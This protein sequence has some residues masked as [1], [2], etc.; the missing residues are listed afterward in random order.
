MT[1]HSMQGVLCPAEYRVQLA[2]TQNHSYLKP[3]A[4]SA[5]NIGEP[6]RMP[7]CYQ[8]AEIVLLQILAHMSMIHHPFRLAT[9][10]TV[11][12]ALSWNGLAAGREQNLEKSF[13][14]T[15][16][17]RL[18]LQAD[19]GSIEITSGGSDKVSVRVERKAKG[20]TE[21]QAEELLAAHEVTFEQAG[22]TVTVAGK[23]K[24]QK[25]WSWRVG[26]PYL[27]VR[28]VVS[29][30]SSFNADLATS[31]GDIRVGDLD[32]ETLAR[33]SSGS[34]KLGRVT[35]K[36]EAS[37]SGG[38]I[39]IA[40]AG[41]GLAART[42]SGS[43]KI[44]EAKSQIDASNSG[45]DIEITEAGGDVSARTSSGSIRLGNA[46]G[47][48]NLR[49]SGGDIKVE[50]AGGTLAAE[51]SSGSIR[52]VRAKGRTVET[53]VSGGDIEIGDAEGAVTAQTSSGSIKVQSAGG[54]VEARNSGGNIEIGSSA[55]EVLASTSSGSLKVQHAKGRMELKNSGGDIDV[56]DVEGTLFA[57]TSSGR[58]KVGSVSGQVQLENSGGDL[59]IEKAGGEA[60]LRTTSGSIVV[61][62]AKAKV[63]AR[64]SGGSIEVAE[65]ADLV[66]A[67]TSSGEIR[68]GWINQPKGESRLHVSGGSIEVALPS[69]ASLN[70]DAAAQG[71]KVVTDLPVTVTVQGE[72]R[73]HALR[74]Q[75][76]AGG[77]AL[78]L[79]ASSGDI[80]LKKSRMASVQAENE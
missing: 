74:G 31:G 18:V 44:T 27:E 77:P 65:A 75:L 61:K 35:G 69:T 34:I 14:V 29:V 76:G 43:I 45:G 7:G 15:P 37:N 38:D 64:D 10:L 78:V 17:G 59:A 70:L 48:V 51:T 72:H 41:G 8:H 67:E 50:S 11:A 5:S 71:G 25:G 26:R 55:A 30:P 36:V 12:L 73:D 13:A 54:R 22:N 60:V 6:C 46:S 28:Y 39:Q 58:I 49:D 33:T 56:G 52:I 3:G 23:Q 42:S 66:L 32:G 62:A 57:R 9:A 2:K 19:Q 16:G 68:V 1:D 53:K 63:D 24:R 20:G 4:P 80:H 47:N 79:R 21:T 40:S